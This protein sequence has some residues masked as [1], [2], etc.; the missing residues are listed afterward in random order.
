MT[1]HRY[2]LAV[3]STALLA[4]SIVQAAA[5]PSPAAADPASVTIAGSLQSELG[6]P[7]DWQP[8]CAATNL[9]PDTDDG[10]WQATFTVPTGDW[11]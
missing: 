2:M 5:P 10:V 6:C 11:E 9:T 4:T 7:G 1:Q 3:I 8:E